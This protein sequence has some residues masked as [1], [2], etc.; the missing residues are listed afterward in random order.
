MNRTF[1]SLYINECVEK[2]RNGDTVYIEKLRNHISLIKGSLR[3]HPDLRTYREIILKDLENLSSGLSGSGLSEK[4]DYIEKEGK[5]LSEKLNLLKPLMVITRPCELNEF[6]RLLEEYDEAGDKREGLREISLEMSC[7]F[8]K[9]DAPEKELEEAKK[10]SEIMS[11]IPFFS[12]LSKKDIEKLCSKVKLKRYDE[13]SLLF[14]EGDR[15]EDLYIIKSGEVK[16]FSSLEKGEIKDYLTLKKGDMFGE[17]GIITSAPRSMSAKVSSEKSELYVITG[18]DFLYI[19]ERHYELS[20]N[21]AKILCKRIED[22]NKRLL[23]YLK[24][25]HSYI[26]EKS[27]VS[28][29]KGEIVK[30]VPLFSV[31]SE[32]EIRRLSSRIKFKRIAG[33]TLLFREGDGVEDLY[34]IKSGEVNLYKELPGGERRDYVTLKKGDMLGEMG[35]IS[36]L[37]RTLS[38]EVS[39]TGG[40]VYVIGK[41]DF[42]YMIKNY[43]H[44]SLNFA[45]ILCKRIDET[46]KRLLSFI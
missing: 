4:I 23:D 21:L 29:R 24:D 45:R 18:K 7:P 39:S 5:V 17:M 27:L 31:L 42:I 14:N 33:R 36:G 1:T 6:S 46:N 15:G 34:I 28:R 16:I 38:A 9:D 25:Y 26:K 11:L 32:E 12:D 37:P 10:K 43:P 35:V 2:I 8:K 20:L 19:L 30:E 13:N 3:N 22:T 41:D 40:E 44:L